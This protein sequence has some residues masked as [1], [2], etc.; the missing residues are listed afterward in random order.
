VR[1]TVATTTSS[2]EYV[3][4]IGF[5]VFEVTDITSN[6]IYGRAVS[7]IYAD[8]NDTNLRRAQRPRLV[9]WN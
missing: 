8:P 1:F 5:T 6:D 9:P 2:G 7:G 4:I 3:D